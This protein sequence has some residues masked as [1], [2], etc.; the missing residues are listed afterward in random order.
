M[1]FGEASLNPDLRILRFRSLF[2]PPAIINKASSTNQLFGVATPPAFVATVTEAL[3]RHR[4][5]FAPRGPRGSI[6]FDPTS[7]VHLLRRWAISTS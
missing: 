5:P 2:R 4:L 1:C 3:P 6:S 7:A